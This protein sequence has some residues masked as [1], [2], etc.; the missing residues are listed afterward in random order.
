MLPY[1]PGGCGKGK[2]REEKKKKKKKKK[3]KTGQNPYPSLI[4]KSLEQQ[5]Y[6]HCCF[7]IQ[8]VC[9][10]TDL[11]QSYQ[12]RFNQINKRGEVHNRRDHIEQKNRK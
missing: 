2:K 5:H 10:S 9:R 6:V 11:P 8:S 1:R 7:S 12:I 3:R 4:K